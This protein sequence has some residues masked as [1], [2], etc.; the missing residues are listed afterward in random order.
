MPGGEAMHV[1][2][3]RVRLKLGNTEVPL[4]STQ[5][6]GGGGVLEYHRLEDSGRIAIVL[7]VAENITLS[8]EPLPVPFMEW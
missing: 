8:P 4:R 6:R 5:L 1:A 2:P 3:E 7:Y